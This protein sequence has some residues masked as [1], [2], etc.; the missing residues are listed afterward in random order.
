MSCRPTLCAERFR[1][2]PINW[3]I[4]SRRTQLSWRPNWPIISAMP[5]DIRITQKRSA[6]SRFVIFL[7]L[8]LLAAIG[9]EKRGKEF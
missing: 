4:C 1:D 3:E 8:I 6:F 2:L 9:P 7:V 5:T